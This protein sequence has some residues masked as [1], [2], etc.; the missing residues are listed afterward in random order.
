LA[1][2]DNQ[3]ACPAPSLS[4]LYVD[5]TLGSDTTTSTAG[6]GSQAC[7]FKSITHA[8]ATAGIGPGSTVHI[9][10]GTYSETTGELYPLTLPNGVNLVG[11]KSTGFPT[12][13]VLTWL[14]G[15]TATFNML[16]ASG[17]NTLDTLTIT[18]QNAQ[19]LAT[20]LGVLVQQNGQMSLTDCTLSGTS[21]GTAIAVEDGAATLSGCSVTGNA[22]GI[23]LVGTAAVTLGKDTAGNPTHVDGQSSD[24]V[25]MLR[26]APALTAT[27]GTTFDNDSEGIALAGQSVVTLSGCELSGDGAAIIDLR[28]CPTAGCAW[29][30]VQGTRFTANQDA[31]NIQYGPGDGP[32]QVDLGGGGGGSTGGNQLNSPLTDKNAHAGLFLQNNGSSG[33][34]VSADNDAWSVCPPVSSPAGPDVVESGTVAGF[35]ATGCTVGN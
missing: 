5:V 11:A 9:A 13:P 34:V 19:G 1:C 15:G 10:A 32:H 23:Q 2:V 21:T 4:D 27:A 33:D 14:T 30:T 25:A 12:G 31:L 29:S 20:D 18:N 22:D 24:G 7:P 35:T 26:G 28:T 17:T 6:N 8:L 3:C 16:N